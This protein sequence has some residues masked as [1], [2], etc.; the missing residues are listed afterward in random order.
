[1]EK[2]FF[3]AIE[4][5]EREKGISPDVLIAALETALLSAYKRHTGDSADNIHIK[6]NPEKGVAK[7][8]ATKK[9]VEEVE[10]PDKEISLAAAKNFKKSYKLGDNFE[11]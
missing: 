10:D 1:M 4:D 8:Y 9:I 6:L 2:D 5:L 11:T 3:L 7:F